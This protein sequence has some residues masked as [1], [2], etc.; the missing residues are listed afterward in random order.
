[1]SRITFGTDGWRG[2]IAEDF[3]YQ[4]VRILTQAISDYLNMLQPSLP[5]PK[6][7]VGYDGRFLSD[8]YAENVA[9][10]LAGNKIKVILAS[11][12]TSTP[13]VSLAIKRQK[14]SG[15]IVI[16][17]SHNPYHFNGVKFRN[18]F[19][20]PASGKETRRIEKFLYKNPVR[21]QDFLEAKE[22]GCIR[23]V[24]LVSPYLA[25]LRRY[26]D[27]RVLKGARLNI[28]VDSM[29][30][31]TG[32][33]LERILKNS[34]LKI[35]AL[36]K[37]SSPLFEGLVPEPILKNLKS[38]ASHMRKGN[39]DIGLA[40][41]GDG[42][43]IAAIDAHGRFI[44]AHEILSCLLLHLVEDRGYS[45]A[46]AKSTSSTSLVDKIARKYSLKLY[47]VPIG[48]KYIASL[49]QHKDILIGGEESGGI[50]FKG[51]IPE[52]DG[53]LA[54]LLLLEMLALRGKSIKQIIDSVE[55]EFGKS[56]YLREDL[57]YSPRMKDKFLRLAKRRPKSLGHEAI[58][59]IEDFDGIKYTL[60]NDSWLLLRLSG[61]ECV[62]RI[63]AEAKTKRKVRELITLGKRL[64][65]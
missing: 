43:R 45:A 62:L 54:G 8:R 51:Y 22:K 24:D 16:T 26:I 36:H 9:S 7:V 21:G 30:G 56:Y 53:V 2:L 64:M 11:S 33:Y 15:G 27:I 3:T 28:L 31:V 20:S 42:D 14:L 59:K 32:G 13:A 41:D 39:F 18:R 17:A 52:R 12:M 57:R 35:T 49:M 55:K 38:L 61:T 19:A 1:M 40:F 29:H 47:S 44:N 5:R 60:S 48:F 25:F 34:S 58:I 65:S 4:N 37:K 50:G 46:V 23:R 10:V 6:V 63:Y